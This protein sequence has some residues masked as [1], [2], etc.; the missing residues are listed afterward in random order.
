MKYLVRIRAPKA[1][2]RFVM[3]VRL[4]V[5]I[6]AT[7]LTCSVSTA[8]AGSDNRL[9]ESKFSQPVL[10]KVSDKHTFGFSFGPTLVPGM[11]VRRHL[12]F[13]ISEK[14]LKE[15]FAGW[16]AKKAERLRELAYDDP[17]IVN[18]GDAAP[19]SQQTI[20][21]NNFVSNEASKFANSQFA[22]IAF[23]WATPEDLFVAFVRVKDSADE[24]DNTGFQQVNIIRGVY[25]D[26]N[27]ST[28]AF[29]L[30]RE[31][32]ELYSQY[33]IAAKIQ[34][35]EIVEPL[36]K[37]S[38]EYF[39]GKDISILV[40][41]LNPQ[42]F[43]EAND[44][45][46]SEREKRQ[47]AVFRSQWNKQFLVVDIV[48]ESKVNPELPSSRGGSNTFFSTGQKL[49]ILA[50]PVRVPI[51]LESV[52]EKTF[53][54][55]ADRRKQ[56]LDNQLRGPTYHFKGTIDYELIER[57]VLNNFLG[58]LYSEVAN[59]SSAE[60]F[61]NGN[62]FVISS[63][64]ND[65]D[66]I[67]PINI[68]IEVNAANALTQMPQPYLGI[69]HT[70]NQEF[71]NSDAN[72]NVGFVWRSLRPKRTQLTPIEQVFRGLNLFAQFE[73]AWR[74][75][76][77][78]DA[79]AGQLWRAPAQRYRLKLQTEDF[80]LGK[81]FNGK[82]VTLA[83][84]ANWFLI[85]LDDYRVSAVD[86]ENRIQSDVSLALNVPI[87]GEGGLQISWKFGRDSTKGFIARPRGE[88]SIVFSFVKL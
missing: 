80:V 13:Q 76:A 71:N 20:K 12:S 67:I 1:F 18:K 36:N 87:A 10:R 70:T 28:I 47:I 33:L 88:A 81:A 25:A 55:D 57:N 34:F 84:D 72:V 52:G 68:R 4:V 24:R 35:A 5:G 31:D 54:T 9:S 19:D 8:F 50:K 21:F 79:K 69:Q 74:P 30:N 11:S 60:T 15:A 32:A 14:G 42:T 16:F 77:Y 27:K 64:K 37:V 22:K 53:K 58:K 65:I 43:D 17:M 85:D 48:K 59:G 82:N 56:F 63:Q 29:A 61:V 83:C 38:K 3:R 7:L 6:V 73:M 78:G 51:S 49:N 45:S 86:I 41:Q 62:K 46:F 75:A 23:E 40:N 66:S 39:C 44:K 2:W 26:V